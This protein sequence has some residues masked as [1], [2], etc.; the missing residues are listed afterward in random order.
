MTNA[1]SYKH[2]KKS[3]LDILDQGGW[4]IECE[5]PLEIRNQESFATIQAARYAIDQIVT[6]SLVEASMV[7]VSEPA[8]DGTIVVTRG[9]LEVGL[10]R[11]A[12]TGHLFVADDAGFAFDEGDLLTIALKL[13]ML[14]DQ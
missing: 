5:S 8:K 1:F 12:G 6:D 9:S 3:T 10:I 11:P 13:R 14:T 2:M 4:V 7:N